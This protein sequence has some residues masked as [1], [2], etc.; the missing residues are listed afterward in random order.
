MKKI[1][2]ILISLILA[3]GI[4]E[5]LPMYLKKE[6]QIE[7]NITNETSLVKQE[8][9][10]YSD[11]AK[12]SYKIYAKGNLIGVISDLDYLNSL[13]K[14]KYKEYEESFPNTELGF[15]N[16]VLIADELTYINYENI[17]DQIM[18][19]LVDNSLLGVKTTEVE[20]ST[21]DGVYEIIYVKN[22]DD[23]YEARDQFLLNF[24]NE[25]TLEKLRNNIK[26]ESPTGLGTVDKNLSLMETISYKEAIVSPDDIFTSVS[27]IY[28]FLCYGRNT[29]REYYTVQEGDTLQ[30]VGYRFGGMLDKQIAMI[31]K[32][33]ISSANQVITPGMQL[34]VTYY[35]S[36]ITVSVTKE[37][38]SQESI[39]PD[40]PEYVEDDS[41]EAGKTEILI[42]EEVG[43]K[44][45]LYEETWVNGVLKDGKQ[46]GDEVVIKNPTRGKIAVGTK[47]VHYIGTG[48][49]VWPVDNPYITTDFGGYLGHTGTDF[50]N[51]YEKDCPV[52]A[53]DSGVVDETGYM[54]DMGNYCII[55]HQ[56]GVR[57]FYMH[58][59]VP[60]YVSEGENVSRGQL[61]GQEGNTGYSFGS[62]LH[63]TFE[64]DG[65]RVNACRYLPCDLIR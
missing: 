65:T 38:L 15:S 5:I 50:I 18:D 44:N 2:A 4:V 62:H 55:D 21:T 17:D 37:V 49:Y 34:N 22:I 27:D 7:A 40:V 63:L 31:N 14:N 26:I 32:D 25:E 3:I 57:T 12:Q 46:I 28:D 9:L 58:L 59:N 8:I 1:I 48:N 6:T 39:T 52:Y 33:I 19:Y 56:N 20:F 36:P 16:D 23:F 41:I 45:V 60:P 53:I 13:I 54:W 47:I 61:I 64:V 29:N 42:Q 24:I 11:E 51:K 35:T 43:I 10:S 30:Y